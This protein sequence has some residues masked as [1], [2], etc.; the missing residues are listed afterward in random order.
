MCVCVCVCVCV[1]VGV[2]VTALPARQGAQ[3][4]EHLAVS[5]GTS[6]GLYPLGL[7]HRHQMGISRRFLLQKLPKQPLWPCHHDQG[8]LVARSGGLASFICPTLS[9]TPD[10]FIQHKQHL[11]WVASR[12]QRLNF[13]DLFKTITG[14]FLVV[15]WLRL[16]APRAAGPGFDPWSR[17]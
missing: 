13:K 14:T 1:V 6:C 2:M 15:Q 3:Q 9:A 4:P 5:K 17:N 11:P 7:C 16:Q 12:Q 8:H 10:P